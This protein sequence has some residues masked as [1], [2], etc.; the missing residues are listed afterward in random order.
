[1]MEYK[2]YHANIR[3]SDEDNFFV[4]DVIGLNDSLA[5]HGIS[6]SELETMFHQSIDNYLDFC[7]EVGKKPEKEYRG[8]FNVRIPAD[9]HRTA[10]IYAHRKNI[11]LNEFVTTAIA[12]EC[13]K[14]AANE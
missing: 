1:M 3:F 9:L 14:I 11:S 10:V 4:G 2:G 6:V 13:A 8:Q 7:K 5:F 12:D